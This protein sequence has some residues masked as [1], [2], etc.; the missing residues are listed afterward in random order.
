MTTSIYHNPACGTSRTVLGILKDAGIEPNIIEYLKNPPTRE[1]MAALLKQMGMTPRQILRRKG[2]LFDDLGL[3]D[4]NL[5][6]D[7]LMDALGS[8]PILME[9]PI[10]VTTKGTRVCRPAEIVREL[11]PD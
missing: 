9:R 10:V 11:L 7:Q 3:G 6:D 2:N 5:T 4:E 1:T 8:H